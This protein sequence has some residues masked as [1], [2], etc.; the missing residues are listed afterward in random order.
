MVVFK[1]KVENEKWKTVFRIKHGFF[2]FLVINF[3]LCKTPSIFQ[4]YINDNFYE[5][6]NTFCSIYIDDNFIYNKTKK[7]MKHVK[8]NQKL[9]KT[10]SQFDIDKYEIFVE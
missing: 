10:G 7:E 8:K 6:L 9:Q 2:E 1:K 3:G 5:Y 4:N